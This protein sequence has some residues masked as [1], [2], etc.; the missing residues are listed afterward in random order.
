MKFYDQLPVAYLEDKHKDFLAQWQFNERA[1]RLR[2]DRHKPAVNIWAG[3]FVCGETVAITSRKDTKFD[4]S[5]GG[6]FVG[7]VNE[8]VCLKAQFAGATLLEAYAEQT[9]HPVQ[10]LI[11]AI[12][13][14]DSM[15]GLPKEGEDLI[16]VRTVQLH[17]SGDLA[18]L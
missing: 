14:L 13:L 4:E 5:Q 16:S 12:I 15:K 10:G 1:F 7:V 18:L 6:L 17:P 11:K 8:E 3:Q 2:G 9:A